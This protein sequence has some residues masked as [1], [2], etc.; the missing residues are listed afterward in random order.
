ME[1]AKTTRG[2]ED[3]ELKDKENEEND[4]K[5]WLAQAK[6]KEEKKEL[7]KKFPNDKITIVGLI[8]IGLILINLYLEGFHFTEEYLKTIGHLTRDVGIAFLSAAIISFLIEI[9]SLLD[10]FKE[11][12]IDALK[13]N[14]YLKDLSYPEL[15]RIKEK[16]N[17]L[18]FLYHGKR[19]DVF[20]NE[21]LIEFENE[22]FKSLLKPYYEYFIATV[23]CKDYSKNPGIEFPGTKCYRK[24]VQTNFKIVNPLKGEKTEKILNPMD[25]YCPEDFNTCES[26]IHL[27]RFRVKIDKGDYK[28]YTL[29]ITKHIDNMDICSYP[30]YNKKLT[31]KL[32][33]EEVKFHFNSEITV[34]MEEVRL[35]SSDDKIYA[36]RV[37]KPT[38]NLT[39]NYLYDN[40]NFK[41]KA[42]CFSTMPILTIDNLI[43]TEYSNSV[44]IESKTWLLPGNGILIA[45]VPKEET[46]V[47]T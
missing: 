36:K 30:N 19:H 14:N 6:E 37:D 7:S 9:P 23:D 25:F 42:D 31:Y 8:G 47:A 1:S 32:N 38:K 35:I 28:D 11:R 18:I 45:I 16:C 5:H 24:V 41:L 46:L 40:P 21:S 34:D 33:N 43:L 44:F 17:K 12:I 20:L 13:D 10:Y 29:E 2:K 27:T 3:E 15:E 26:L 39:I 4:H 22:I